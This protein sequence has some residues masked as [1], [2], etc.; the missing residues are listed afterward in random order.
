MNA[1]SMTIESVFESTDMLQY[2][3]PHFQREFA[4]EKE[5]WQTL[6]DD[7]MEVYQSDA[8]P[9]PEHF[10]GSLVVIQHEGT[11]GKRQ[12]YTLVD[13][14][15]R[16][17]SISLLLC[18]LRDT[19]SADDSLRASI[20]RLLVNPKEEGRARYK[21]LPTSK[22][23]DSQA[24]FAILNGELNPT[25]ESGI[26]KA[27]KHYQKCL[28][29]ASPGIDSAEF[30]RCIVSGMQVV[31]IKLQR[32]EQAHRI[33]ESLN[34]RG[35][36]LTQADLVRNYVAMK[37]P[38]ER[39]ERAF[40][41]HWD[42]I[43]NLLHEKRKVARMGELSAFLRHYLAMNSGV[44]PKTKRVYTRFRVHVETNCPT[45]EDFITE[46][47]KLNRFAKF[48]DRL[49]RPENES[50]AGIRIGISRLNIVLESVSY[51]LLLKF[52]EFH[53]ERLIADVE[54]VNA[55]EIIENY[56]TR[57][58]LSGAS[59]NS[60]N[61]IFAALPGEL[62]VENFIPTMT[63]LLRSKKYPRNSD[64]R[65][66]MLHKFE[67]SNRSR[68]RIIFILRSI[69][70]HL[71]RD[72]G[73]FSVLDDE[74]S[75]E[76][77]L[78]KNPDKSWKEHLGSEWQQVRDQYLDRIGNITLVTEEWNTAMSNGSFVAKQAKLADH[79]LK[80]NSDY[81]A[82][83]IQCWDG[84]A[85]VD[86]SDWFAQVAIQVWA[87]FGGYSPARSDIED[88][89][90]TLLAVDGQRFEVESWR[91]V[92]IM[93]VEAIADRFDDFGAETARFESFLSHSGAGFLAKHQ[94]ANGY[95]L[96]LNH[97][98]KKIYEFCK[99]FSLRAGLNNRDWHVEYE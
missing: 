22:Y 53:D 99:Q 57:R 12:K 40:N 54:F 23:S 82:R 68:E 91:Q 61:N 76:H 32:S 15:Q 90:P 56:S 13:G 38:L 69:E 62:D 3:L 63:E 7:V 84:D 86:R 10:M 60:L 98:N 93:T 25:Y 52:F 41:E 35:R 18:A 71:S 77:I 44:L 78:P 45:P 42:K 81:F 20:E 4:W 75:I 1:A 87:P 6:F 96:K 5:E 72:S 79:A 80:I 19:L 85:I 73:G 14:Q 24:Y 26:V 88:A 70:R 47:R 66:N 29:D 59:T 11:E 94:L 30:F 37:L 31:F 8:Q 58:F 27:W 50:N 33:F 21:I 46:L 51:P 9:R 36:D 97:S 92:L 95:W 67:Y 43:D 17:T 65:Q 89:R 49:V 2:V 16:L 28:R 55:L 34:A 74:P 83:D 64:I 48:Y 39:Q